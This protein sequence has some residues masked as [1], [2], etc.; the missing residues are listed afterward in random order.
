[1]GGYEN[2]LDHIIGKVAKNYWKTY[3][4]FR[5]RFPKTVDEALKIYKETGTEF[6]S[7]FIEKEMFNVRCEFQEK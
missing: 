4:K 5:F 3:H 2:K 6:W 7:I 1:M